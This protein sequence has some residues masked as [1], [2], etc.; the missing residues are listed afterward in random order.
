MSFVQIIGAFRVYNADVLLIA[1]GVTLLTS[2]LK[3]TVMKKVSRKLY[4]F[5]PF[6]VGLIAFA[7]YRAL[8]TLSA[9]PFTT[10]LL[11]TLEGGFATGCAATL[12]YVFYEQ[13]IRGKATTF[14]PL[15]PLL[16]GI[17]P[18]KTRTK[19]AEELYAGSV[20]LPADE[21]EGFFNET[22]NGYADPPLGE[23]DKAALSKVLAEYMASIEKK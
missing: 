15:L 7:V 17:V 14:S 19:A 22:L 12:Y 4:V 16:E 10:E 23:A 18:D 5:L 13:L 2:L 20:S 3:K 21:R 6:V 9:A 8:V 11:K 1:L